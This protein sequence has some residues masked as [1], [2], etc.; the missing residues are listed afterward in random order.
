VKI[1]PVLDEIQSICRSLSQAG[2]L[3]S[4]DVGD[5]H[6]LRSAYRQ[7]AL[8]SLAVIRARCADIER[9]LQIE[10]E[11]LA[12]SPHGHAIEDPFDANPF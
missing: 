4:V 1:S 7:L 10:L 2:R 9:A 12:A 6:G 11:D 3:R 8:S 5:Q